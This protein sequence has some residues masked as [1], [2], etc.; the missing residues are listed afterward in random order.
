MDVGGWSS[1]I[2][3]TLVPGTPVHTSRT[4]ELPV[5]ITSSSRTEAP[6]A[7]P[8][9]IPI[10]V[11]AAVMQPASIVLGGGDRSTKLRVSPATLATLPRVE[12]VE[13]LAK[14]VEPS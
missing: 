7:L 4:T 3:A 9:D 14:P 5:S 1:G 2:S 8:D 10:W 6:V 12:V 13:D 11:D